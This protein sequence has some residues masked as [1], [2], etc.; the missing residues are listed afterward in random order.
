MEAVLRVL[1]VALPA[2]LLAQALRKDNPALALTVVIAA[3]VVTLGLTA[4]ALAGLAETITALAE[5]SG[6]SQ[7]ALTAVLKALGISILTRLTA[8]L[9]K[10][11]GMGAASS[12]AELAGTA[13]GIYVSLPLL[14]ALLDTVT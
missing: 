11:A 12:A 10:D 3:A 1:A 8:D 5:E 14:L 2:G 9:L 6:V 13:A 7:A 4:G